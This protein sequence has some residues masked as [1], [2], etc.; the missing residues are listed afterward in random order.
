MTAPIALSFELLAEKKSHDNLQL[1][2]G[3]YCH[4]CD[5][6]YLDNDDTATAS[7]DLRGNLVRLLEQWRS[8]VD[9]LRGTVGT[10]YL[11]YDFSDE[12]TGW[13]RVGS[14]DGHNA[15]VQAG[16]SM[17]N[18]WG[19]TPSD[20]LATASE[21]TD[22]DAEAHARIECSLDDLSQRIAANAETFKAP[23]Q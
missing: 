13:L 10:A 17:V 12:C 15:E 20:Y 21:I 16:W 7:P 22:F 14:A 6:F 4:T 19:F 18:G 9:G 5:S 23:K 2:L 11:P 1:R 3:P 8:Q